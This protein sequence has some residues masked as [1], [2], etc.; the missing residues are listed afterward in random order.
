MLQR[1]RLPSPARRLSGIVILCLVGCTDRPFADPVEGSTSG[2][3]SDPPTEADASTSMGD[4][5]GSS[6]GDTGTEGGETGS[7][8][9]T[10]TEQAFAILEENCSGCHSP[11][12]NQGGFDTVL[13]VDALLVEGRI[14]A[15]SPEESPLYQAVASAKMPPLDPLRDMELA[16]LHAWIAE[17][18]GVTETDCEPPARALSVDDQIQ[19]MLDDL[20]TL[21]PQARPHIRYVSLADS[22]SAGACAA[23]IET[24]GAALSLMLN[25]T[26]FDPVV[27]PPA[28]VDE[29]NLIWRIDLRHYAWDAEH[30]ANPDGVDKWELITE[31]SS[32]AIEYGGAPAQTLQSMT[33]TLVPF[34]KGLPLIDA[35]SRANTPNLLGF[36][37]DRE[38]GLYGEMFGGFETLFGLET[39]VGV[40]LQSADS[41]RLLLASSPEAPNRKVAARNSSPHGAVWSLQDAELPEDFDVSFSLPNGLQGYAQFD[42]DGNRV[43]ERSSAKRSVHGIDRASTNGAASCISCHEKGV[44]VVS[45]VEQVE[46][47]DAYYETLIATDV[48][49]FAQALESAWPRPLPGDPLGRALNAYEA[50]VSAPRLAIEVGVSLEELLA[51]LDRLPEPFGVLAQPSGAVDRR[52]VE[53][54]YPEIVCAMADVA[55]ELTCG[56]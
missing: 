41:V 23:D 22:F 2:A 16:I 44:E 3:S 24:F 27:T 36:D 35:L 21:D 30:P 4:S 25:S 10:I 11:P 6:E 50:P 1:M 31:T 15:G 55:P 12:A 17:C 32:Y 20:E 34:M 51:S 54:H 43:N 29:R 49:T 37:P 18:T 53:R 26:S 19:T 7:L 46:P 52:L 8:C 45:E 47:P 40:D 33:G 5:G 38:A 42:A 39:L 9:A 56:S 28:P 48:A 13:D 14:V